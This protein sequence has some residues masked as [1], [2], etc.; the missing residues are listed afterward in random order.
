MDINELMTILTALLAAA[1][2]RY[3]DVFGDAVTLIKNRMSSK[4]EGMIQDQKDLEDRINDLNDHNSIL[5]RDQDALLRKNYHLSKE[6]T[7]LRN[8][9]QTLDQNT[10]MVSLRIESSQKIRVIKAVRNVFNLSLKEAHDLVESG[11]PLFPTPVTAEQANVLLECFSG[12]DC[13]ELTPVTTTQ[14]EN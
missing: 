8:R 1:A 7:V 3:D 13:L 4:I 14:I 10:Y 9:L 6:L 12:T 2:T 5:V 11:Q